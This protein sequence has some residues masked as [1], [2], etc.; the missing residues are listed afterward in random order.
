MKRE[1]IVQDLIEKGVPMIFKTDYLTGEKGWMPSTLTKPDQFYRI[2]GKV[3]SKNL[4]FAAIRVGLI[5]N[6]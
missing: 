4:A 2:N 1:Y 5:K 6:N 3:V